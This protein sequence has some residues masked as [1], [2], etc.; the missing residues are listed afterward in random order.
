MPIPIFSAWASV[1]TVLALFQEKTK[2]K[3]EYAVPLPSAPAEVVL[4]FPLPACNPFL[5]LEKNLLTKP[6]PSF[7]VRLHRRE[8][9]PIQPVILFSDPEDLLIPPP[10]P[11]PH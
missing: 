5:E 7:E 9:L 4:P 11:R 3:P 10:S 8:P 2:A 1:K 6:V